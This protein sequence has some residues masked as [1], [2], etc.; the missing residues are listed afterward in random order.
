MG[1]QV[2]A[3]VSA[4]SFHFPIGLV[5]AYSAIMLVQLEETPDE[6]IRIDPDKKSW[7]GKFFFFCFNK[8]NWTTLSRV[9][10]NFG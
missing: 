2:L 7:I 10:T 1:R 4:A 6:D 5:V 9:L 8:K 3:C